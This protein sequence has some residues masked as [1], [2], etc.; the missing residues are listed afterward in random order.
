[1]ILLSSFSVGS[2]LALLYGRGAFFGCNERMQTVVN[3][4]DVFPQ[5]LTF[6]KNTKVKNT[7]TC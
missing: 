5:D 3:V 7:H 6:D 2:H 1:M 4:H